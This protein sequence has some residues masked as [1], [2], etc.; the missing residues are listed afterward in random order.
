LVRAYG[1]F[2]ICAI[3]PIVQNCETLYNLGL[4][5]VGQTVTHEVMRRS[6]FAHFCAGESATDIKPKL[7]MLRAQGVGGILD[8]A[9]EA[10]DPEASDRRV[11][12][13]DT[14]R[15]PQ[16]HGE[17]M[18]DQNLEIFVEAIRAVQATTP[19]GFAAIK[20]SGLGKPEL[21]E[22]VS[23]ALVECA[24]FF[25]RLHDAGSG[26]LPGDPGEE[27]PFYL[28]ER[29][30]RLD[31]ATFQ[32]GWRA[33]FAEESDA[34]LA[35]RFAALDKDGDGS[36]TY[37]DW[38]SSLLLEDLGTVVA[39]CT[40]EGPLYRAALTAEEVDLLKALRFR[41]ETLM[42]LASELGVR[43]MVDAEWIGIQPAIDHVVVNLQRKYNAGE[44]RVVFCTYQMYL[45]G[46]V[47]RVHRDLARSKAEGWHFAA[48]VVRGAYMVSERQKA[49]ARGVESPVCATYEETEE[50]YHAGLLAILQH[51]LGASPPAAAALPGAGPAEVMVASHNK[52]SVEFVISTMAELGVSKETVYFGQLLGMADHLTFPLG[53]NGYK[54][55]KYV[56]Y[57][58]IG[59]VMPYLIRRTQEN[60]TLLGS[61]EVQ[62]ERAMVISELRRRILG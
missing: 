28:L 13:N 56:P 57:G 27:I 49:S 54:A 41:A 30:L 40:E 9:A 4:R 25:K 59:E 52:R 51:N 19:N 16:Y 32:R 61:A 50:N 6:F 47:Q 62:N 46:M 12:W 2:K 8:Y 36:I 55:Y 5:L 17:A 33:F 21:L 45:R 53:A 14:A 34:A 58:P 48:K 37:F 26:T 35:A 39:Q 7:E 43:V 23:N 60:S 31:L 24:R 38:S 42:D 18:C 10:P 11:H 22:R 20:L 15:I 44:N 1:I 3:R 29:D